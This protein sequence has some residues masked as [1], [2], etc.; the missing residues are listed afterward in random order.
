MPQPIALK[1]FTFAKPAF[2]P[3]LTL[4]LVL[5][6]L[7]GCSTSDLAKIFQ[8]IDTE[9]MSSY[10]QAKLNC[11]VVTGIESKNDWTI[12]SSPSLSLGLRLPFTSTA[13]DEIHYDRKLE[14]Y[15]DCLR[16]AGI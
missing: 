12:F 8:P 9:A 11:S 7:G 14:D 1:L 10:E 4:C 16:L 15:Y 5:L 2:L 3:K 6:L 13:E